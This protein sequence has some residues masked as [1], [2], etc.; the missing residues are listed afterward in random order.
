MV[1]RRERG[2]DRWV[3]V[4]VTLLV[5]AGAVGFALV[6]SLT[7]R[8]EARAARTELEQARESRIEPSTGD[9]LGVGAIDV[10]I[11]PRPPTRV[12]DSTS[13]AWTAWTRG[14]RATAA[15]LY[16]AD[17]EAEPANPFVAY[18]LGLA[19]WKSG[20]LDTAVEAMTRAAALAPDSLRARINLSRIHNA[21]GESEA[22]LAAADAALRLDPSDPTA[23]YQRAR[24]LRNLG[25]VDQAVAVLAECLERRPAY[26]HALNLLGLIHLE[27]GELER[28]VDTLAS[29]TVLE[30][31][32][33][34][35]HRNLAVALAR[36]GR[37]AEATVTYRRASDLEAGRGTGPDPT[38]EVVAV[39]AGVQAPVEPEV[40]PVPEADPQR[41]ASEADAPGPH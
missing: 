4:G 40:P 2:N 15:T 22:A 6:G 35:V 33:A 7:N 18:M 38:A 34:F 16:A 9:S 12:A 19:A 10:P 30:P 36:D 5:V 24:S 8:E 1:A 25:R 27:R 28:A 29:A 31:T 41:T 20:D 11:P 17:L 3:L 14:D 39:A 13:D 21:R 37:T 32:L 26:G 23:L